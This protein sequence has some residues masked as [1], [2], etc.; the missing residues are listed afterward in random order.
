MTRRHLHKQ[1]SVLAP[2]MVA[3]GLAAFAGSAA[4]APNPT[5]NGGWE[6]AT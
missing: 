1:L 3:L 5:P 4:A 2:A 6:L